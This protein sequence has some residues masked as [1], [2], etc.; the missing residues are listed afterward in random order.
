MPSFK[1]LRRVAIR[2]EKGRVSIRL[3]CDDLIQAGFVPAAWKAR[4]FLLGSAMARSVSGRPLHRIVR[5]QSAPA[6]GWE[7]C[8]HLLPAK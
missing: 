4:T 5:T 7:R 1:G 8:G 2:S 6:T 3:K